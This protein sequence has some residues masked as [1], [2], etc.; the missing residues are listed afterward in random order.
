MVISD[1]VLES[2][3]LVVHKLLHYYFII[4]IGG[5]FGGGGDVHGALKSP[6]LHLNLS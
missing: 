4:G 2:I 6:H 5:N 1:V 3:Y